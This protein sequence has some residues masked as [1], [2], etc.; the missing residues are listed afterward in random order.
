MATATLDTELF[1]EKVNEFGDEF[2]EWMEDQD[3]TERE[4]VVWLFQYYERYGTDL[5]SGSIVD[6]RKYAA[7][8]L[9]QSGALLESLGDLGSHHRAAVNKFR[10]ASEADLKSISVDNAKLDGEEQ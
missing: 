5:N 6:Y 3:L 10:E 1:P 8:Y 7:Q 9:N 2:M 4:K